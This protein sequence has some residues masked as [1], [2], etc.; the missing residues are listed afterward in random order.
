MTAIATSAPP[1]KR[2]TMC[3]TTHQNRLRTPAPASIY[4]YECVDG[5]AKKYVKRESTLTRGKKRA[6]SASRNDPYEW[7]K[8]CNASCGKWRAILRIMDAKKVMEKSGPD[9]ERYCVMNMWDEKIASC[10]APQERKSICRQRAVRH[11]S[12]RMQHDD[13]KIKR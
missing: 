8:C 4:G 13:I 9:G 11:G 7:I 10:A 1:R 12:C 2:N 6:V 3:S 5:K